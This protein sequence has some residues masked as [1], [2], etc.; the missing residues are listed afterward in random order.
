M[1]V[2]VKGIEEKRGEK[3][4]EKRKRKRKRKSKSKSKRKRKGKRKGKR[5]RGERNEERREKREEKR[6]GRKEREVHCPKE[7]VCGNWTEVPGR[8]RAKSL[9][10]V[11]RG[12]PWPREENILLLEAR[13][14]CTAVQIGCSYAVCYVL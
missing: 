9:W 7:T 5:K 10:T 4:E 11:L 6:R 13:A 2:S 14:L 12:R 3:R 1:F 8:W